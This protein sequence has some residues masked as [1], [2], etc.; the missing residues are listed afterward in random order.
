MKT[1]F[2]TLH[3]NSEQYFYT[4]SSAIHGIGL[5]SEVYIPENSVL[6][7][8]ND[9]KVSI[10]NHS[11]KPNVLINSDSEL[12][13]LFSIEQ[14]EELVMSYSLLNDDGQQIP[15]NCGTAQCTNRINNVNVS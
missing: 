11:C 9:P 10:I 3:G 6:L 8:A 12:V 13:S 15:C 5:F 2:L 7:S 14:N 4:A 1:Y